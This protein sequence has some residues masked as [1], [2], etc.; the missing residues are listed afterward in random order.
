MTH[1]VSRL[2]HCSGQPSLDLSHIDLSNEGDAK[3][4]VKSVYENKFIDI[5]L[6]VCGITSDVLRTLAS[7]LR[8]NTQLQY[9]FLNNNSIDSTGIATITGIL[10]VNK[11]I[12]SINLRGNQ[13]FPAEITYTEDDEEDQ[14]EIE[15]L[16]ETCCE[17]QNLKSICGCGEFNQ[18]I[19][20]SATG[21]DSELYSD[22][23]LLGIELKLG[24]DLT[25]LQYWGSV[26]LSEVFEAL[27]DNRT[28]LHAQ[29]NRFQEGTIDFDS[30]LMN[31]LQSNSNLKS[32]QFA[33]EPFDAS[34]TVGYGK[35]QRQQQAGKNTLIAIWNSLEN[36]V[37]VT[38]LQLDA[39]ARDA[40]TT[41]ALA[42]LL[43]K[44]ATLL[45][46]SLFH[47]A[48]LVE[49]LVMI[50]HSLEYNNTLRVISV[51]KTAYIASD[52]SNGRTSPNHLTQSSGGRST[53][54][55]SKIFKMKPPAG[56]N[57]LTIPEVRARFEAA[58][59]ARKVPF[60]IRYSFFLLTFDFTCLENA[61]QMFC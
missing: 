20:V 1:L 29:F 7:S 34:N 16:V 58:Y 42:V 32:L 26:G 25:S 53:V 45:H 28:V 4:V 24:V 38:S 15:E 48:L 59:K 12:E 43:R 54:R 60:I 51:N 41:A 56:T 13:L 55:G 8:K 11:N 9:L 21:S 52:T 18:E 6:S 3:S 17:L 19:V 23:L 40:D 27:K 61:L 37:G 22:I 39:W 46:L 5:D 10:R 57:L 36:N 47:T 44:N 50:A 35:L 31:C 2:Q 14:S 33:F 30:L 49:D